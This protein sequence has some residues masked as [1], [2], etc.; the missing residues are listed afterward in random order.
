MIFCH[1]IVKEELS[2]FLEVRFPINCV[3]LSPDK[4][5][6]G[7]YFNRGLLKEECELLGSDIKAFFGKSYIYLHISYTRTEVII[8]FNIDKF[9]MN[10]RNKKI[11]E[12]IK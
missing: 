3:E 8:E 11:D 9:I 2:K 5:Y 12:I 4:N 7:A 1:D 6:C 10:R